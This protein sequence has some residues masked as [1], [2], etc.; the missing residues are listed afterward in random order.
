VTGNGS[1][2]PFGRSLSAR[3]LLLTVVF[4]L[5]GEILIFVPSI[6]RFRLVY[7]EDRIAAAHLSTIGLGYASERPSPPIEDALLTHAG[8]LSVTI[9]RDEPV[10]ELGM[11][12]PATTTID[13]AETSW[14]RLVADAALTLLHRGQRVIRVVGPSPMERGTTV[15]VTLTELPLY[16][17]MTDYAWRIL[18]LSL[19][20][21]LI[22]AAMLFV[23]LRRL[24][25]TPLSTITAKLALFRQR[26]EDQSRDGTALGRSDEIGIVDREL[27]AMTH[28]LRQAL[29]QKTRLAALGETVSKLNHDL[30]NILAT[31]LLVS[32]RLEQSAAPAVRAVAPKL[33]QTLERA[34]RLCQDALDFAKSRPPRPRLASVELRQL[35][36]EVVAALQP[37]PLTRIENTVAAG[38]IVRGDPDQL[39]RLFLNLAKNAI[40]AMPDGGL[41]TFASRHDR[42]SVTV[43]IGDT[44]PGLPEAVQQ[45]LFQPFARTGDSA[46]TGLGLAISREI[47]RAHGGELALLATGADGTTFRLSLPA[48]AIRAAA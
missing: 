44:G 3:L 39:H 16:V 11:A 47:A 34:I 30:R 4:L 10:L 19:V 15:E 27:E 20:L 48:A 35:I 9:I 29:A 17:A 24:I 7:L 12:A 25:V 46:G 26:P 38:S 1:R 22:V 23:A 42:R 14:P 13:V 2:P 43:E 5:L 6:A 40:E 28:D 18:I 37:P 32:D 33:I 31:A 45:R 36:D 21:S 41:L 8:V